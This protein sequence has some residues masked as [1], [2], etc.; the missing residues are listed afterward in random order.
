M[1]LLTY[2]VKALSPRAVQQA[3][4]IGRSFS[5]LNRPPPNYAGHVPLTAIEKGALAAGSAVMSLINPQ[6]GG[7]MKSSLEDPLC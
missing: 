4:G 1:A 3:A 7:T 5:V 6:R 2:P